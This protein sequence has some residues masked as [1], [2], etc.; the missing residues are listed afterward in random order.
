MTLTREFDFTDVT[1]RIELSYWTWYDIEEGWDYLYLES[2]L[3]GEAWEILRTPSCRDDDLSGNAYGCGYTGKSGGAGSARW[4]QESI[5][6]SQYAGRKVQLRFEYVT[7]A[8]LHG[9]GLLLD[10][11]SIDA[12][13][14]SEDL[15]AGEGEWE[16]QGFA[17]IENVLPQTFRLAL[18]MMRNDGTTVEYPEVSDDQTATIPL[19]LEGG[20]SAVLLVT[21]TQ[22]FTRLPASYTIEAR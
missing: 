8:A 14:Y 18:V 5:D 6:L 1:G 13:G 19:S 2:S 21:G 9:E 22:R 11:L 4:T 20:E 16:A 7:D 12:I 3:D 15:E 17:R 10:D